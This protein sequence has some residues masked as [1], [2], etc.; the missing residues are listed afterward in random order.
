MYV[1]TKIFLT[2]GRGTHRER[3][4][5]FEEALRDAGIGPFN[6]ICVSSIFPPHC[7]LIS[8]EEGR[9]MLRE[10]QILH[11][12]MSKSETNEPSRLI[13]AA[14]GLAIPKDP[15]QYGY[16]SEHH[17]FGQTARE[18]GLYSEVLAANMLA[19]VLGDKEVRYTKPKGKKGATWR[20]KPKDRNPKIVKTTSITCAIEGDRMGR[21]STVLA[22]AV[23]I[24]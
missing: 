17:S 11:V 12:V 4:T 5:S 14:V 23:L 21:W 8:R 16:L 2:E 20:I 15:S 10:G 7:K 1:P 22:A 18:A 24:P 3:L 13:A 19:T 9:P 6:I